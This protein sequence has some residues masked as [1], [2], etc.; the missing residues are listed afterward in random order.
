MDTEKPSEE[1][2]KTHS[3]QH[4][5]NC[6]RTSKR[7]IENDPFDFSKRFSGNEDL[8]EKKEVDLRARVG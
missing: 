8:E 6:C 3:H 7:E 2:T 5:N 1:S 4:H